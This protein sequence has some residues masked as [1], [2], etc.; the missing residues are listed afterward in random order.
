MVGKRMGLY[1]SVKTL[2]DSIYQSEVSGTAESERCARSH[3]FSTVNKTQIN[4]PLIAEAKYISLRI[5]PY[6]R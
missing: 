6:P 3:L 4:S 5:P 1:G 2:R